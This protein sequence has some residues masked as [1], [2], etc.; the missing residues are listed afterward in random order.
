MG[1]GVFGDLGAHVSPLGA[2]P[3]IVTGR[4]SARAT[5]MLDTALAMLPKAQ[6]FDQVDENPAVTL[7]D[8][9]A[10]FCR[11]HGCDCIVALGG[12]SPMDAAKAIALLATNPGEC[13]AY[14]GK[15]EFDAPPLPIIAVPTTAGT[16]SEVTPYAVLV[17][18]AGQRKNTL[19]GTQLFP[20]VAL[21]DPQLSVTMPRHVTISTGLDALSQAMEG[22]LSLKSTAVGDVFALEICR[23]V[24]RWLP[25]AADA[26]DDLE[27]RARMLQAAMLSGCVI[28]QSGTT[29]VHG[30]GYYFT[31]EFG[32]AHGLA[33]AL[34]LPP[35]F[36]HNARYEPKK[37]ASLANVLGRPAGD[38]PEE[39][40]A[41]VANALH[42]LFEELGVSPAAR[43]AGVAED[44]L[45]WCAEDL[46]GDPY[47][48]KN[49]VGEFTVDD[50][51]D[52]FEDAFHGRIGMV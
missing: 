35:V 38:D 23:L 5:G 37:V 13:T 2:K 28:A 20:R 18:K 49:Q 41:G 16:G 27:A 6:V 50:V 7:C 26:P 10:A 39:A 12:G 31:L 11:E 47:R 3:L 9:G 40:G 51:H 52:M 14:F 17:D 32:V 25:R 46:H 30:A 42:E 48:F 33:N 19:R 22:M 24:K 44:R 34:L 45:R 4:Q 36:C 1:P 8:A 43:D 21:L 15:A 29:L